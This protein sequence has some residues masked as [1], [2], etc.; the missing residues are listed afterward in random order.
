[1]GGARAL[2]PLPQSGRFLALLQLPQLQYAVVLGQPGCSGDRKGSGNRGPARRAAPTPTSTLLL[3]G[4]TTSPP[5]Y[6]AWSW[7]VGRNWESG[8]GLIASYD[9]TPTTYGAVPV[10]PPV[11]ESAALPVVGTQSDCGLGDQAWAAPTSDSE[12]GL[13]NLGQ[14]QSPLCRHRRLQKDGRL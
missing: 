11:A 2:R 14:Q 10:T 1:M 4:S 13:G 5:R 6:L 9:G 7:N 3:G 8:P 12:T